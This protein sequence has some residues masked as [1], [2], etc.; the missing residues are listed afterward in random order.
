MSNA[1]RGHDAVMAEAPNRVGELGL[2]GRDR[3]ALTGRDDLARVEGEAAHQAERAARRIAIARAERAGGVLDE[4]DLL[5][6]GGLQLLPFDRPAEEVDGE[7][8]LRS[9]R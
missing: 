6:D 5:R 7:H 8:G 4:H 3:A 1:P 9:R 2:V